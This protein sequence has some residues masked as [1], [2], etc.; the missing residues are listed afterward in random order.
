M[1]TGMDRSLIKYDFKTKQC[2]TL[3]FV[4]S[5]KNILFGFLIRNLYS[6][7]LKLSVICV[8][9]YVYIILVASLSLSR[10]YIITN[11]VC[12]ICSL[13][14]WQYNGTKTTV[15]QHI[16]VRG[17]SSLIKSF[18]QKIPVPN[19]LYGYFSSVPKVHIVQRFI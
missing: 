19:H 11:Y 13:N 9:M 2:F 3:M 10:L 1:T 5:T 15:I 16:Q 18:L 7:F 14:I 6:F 4:L 12:F 17:L 8:C